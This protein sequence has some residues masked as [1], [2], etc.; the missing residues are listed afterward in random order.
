MAKETEARKEEVVQ[1][2]SIAEQELTV[3]P[4]ECQPWLSPGSSKWQDI[5]ANIAAL[6]DKTNLVFLSPSTIFFFSLN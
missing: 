4:S 5:P 1:K 3:R 6:S 2:K